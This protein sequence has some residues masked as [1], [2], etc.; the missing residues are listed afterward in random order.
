ML[1]NHFKPHLSFGYF[2]FI[3]SYLLTLIYTDFRWL[4]LTLIYTDVYWLLLTL[5]YTDVH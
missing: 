4:L 3:G 1:A 5:I 2:M